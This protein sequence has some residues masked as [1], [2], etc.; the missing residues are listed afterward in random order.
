[1]RKKGYA[2]KPKAP[3]LIGAVLFICKQKNEPAR[4][5]TLPSLMASTG[6]QFSVFVFTHFF[7]A[8]FYDAAQLITS[9]HGILIN[10]R[11]YKYHLGCNLSIFF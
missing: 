3:P 6:Q 7:P 9:L 2:K 5:F 4:L 1:L 8:L 10:Q 11:F